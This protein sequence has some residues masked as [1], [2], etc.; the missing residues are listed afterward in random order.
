LL[1]EVVEAG[2]IAHKRVVPLP[3][4]GPEMIITTYAVWHK[5]KWISSAL[6]AFVSLLKKRIADNLHAP[7][8]SK[9][10]SV[11][12]RW[13]QRQIQRPT[14]VQNPVQNAVFGDP[15]TSEADCLQSSCCAV[16]MIRATPSNSF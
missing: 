8:C 11:S 3:W 6:S 7:S 5:D 13:G 4:V 16:L 2:D 14:G 1:P 15:G 12:L 9:K 10:E